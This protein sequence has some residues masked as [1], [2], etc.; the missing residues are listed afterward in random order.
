MKTKIV[1]TLVPLFIIGLSLTAWH[2]FADTLYLKNGRVVEG[3]IKAED[4]KRV[5]IDFEYGTI[6]F[7]K[8]D[9]E[10]IQRSTPDQSS[11]IRARWGKRKEDDAKATEDQKPAVAEGKPQGPRRIEHLVVLAVLNKRI[12][13]RLLLDTGASFI[14]LTKQVGQKLGIDDAY[15]EKMVQLTLGDGRKVS[16]AYVSLKSVKVQ[17][18]EASDVPAAVLLEDTEMPGALDGMLGMSFLSRFNFKVDHEKR[19]L[20]LEKF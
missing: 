12:P 19:R 9:I 13:V 14:I 8:D 2:V 5:K 10:R 11:L 16:A 17:E 1:L 3:I 6:E 15:G 4:D 7:S 18:A 20:I